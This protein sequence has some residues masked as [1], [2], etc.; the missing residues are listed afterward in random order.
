MK[1]LWVFLCVT[2]LVFGTVAI[3]GATTLDVYDWDV[4]QTT[5]FGQIDTIATAQ[6]GASHYDY[7]S[8]SGHPS[9]VNLGTYNSN[10]WI[11]ENTGTGEYT[12]GFI[13]SIDNSPDSSNTAL[14][15]FRIV[16]STSNVYVSQSDDP[17]EATETSPGTFS[18]SYVYGLNT[19]GIAVSGITGS[20]WT[21]MIDSVNFGDIENWYAASGETSAFTDDLT[22]TLGHQYRIV[23]E[24]ETPSGAP[25]TGSVPEPATMLLLGSGLIGL[26]GFRRKKLFKE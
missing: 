18:G 19:D 24:G 6:T 7:Y 22:L 13:F 3:A 16:D 8:V 9:N 15:N 20:G 21:V 11:H 26:V 5:L 4:S 14:L 23:L 12:F 2:F 25:I 17:G 1:K 10:F